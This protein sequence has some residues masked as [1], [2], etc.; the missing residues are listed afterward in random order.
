MITF[1]KNV[2]NE[3]EVHYLSIE[4]KFSKRHKQHSKIHYKF[5]P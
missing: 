4:S 3:T 5:K 1:E 2:G